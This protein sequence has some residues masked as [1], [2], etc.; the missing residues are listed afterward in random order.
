MTCN[1]RHPMSLRHPVF[2]GLSRYVL[3]S[4]GTRHDTFTWDVTHSHGTWLIH[5]CHSQCPNT[6][7]NTER[8]IIHSCETRLIHVRH[9]SFMCV[10]F[11]AP[12]YTAQYRTRHNSFI[13]E[14]RLIH[15][16][17]DS[18]MCAI[19]SPQVY[20]AIQNETHPCHMRHDSFRWDRTHS[21]ET[22]FDI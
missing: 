10:Q 1:L 20:C 5:V 15:V 13:C 8:G 22:L 9:D 6:L 12:K 2:P 21:F 18:F 4:T 19:S 14:T 11:P 17:H 3:H 16:R 7:R